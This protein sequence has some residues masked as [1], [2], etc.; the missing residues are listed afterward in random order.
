MSLLPDLSVLWV[1]VFV[2]LLATILNVLLFKPLIR[3]MEQ[4]Q[5]QVVLKQQR[6][7]C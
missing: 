5:G 4:R 1:I 3:V 6:R 2:L 7:S